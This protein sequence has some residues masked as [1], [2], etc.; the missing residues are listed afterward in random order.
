MSSPGD[1]QHASGPNQPRDVRAVG[2]AV[3]RLTVSWVWEQ[4]T[5][6][7]VDRFEVELGPPRGA[8]EWQRD[9]VPGS[10]RQYTAANLVPSTTYEVRVRS[11]RDVTGPDGS[12]TSY[13]SPWTDPVTGQTLREGAGAGCPVWPVDMTCCKDWPTDPGQWTDRHRDAVERATEIL[14]VLT[15]GKYGPCAVKVRPCSPDC[16]QQVPLGTPWWQ[17][18][19]LSTG[20]ATWI[21]PVLEGGRWFN[22]MCGCTGPCGCGPMCRYTLPW[23]S[24]GVCQVKI[25]GQVIPKDPA[26]GWSENG[27]R[28]YLHRPD[29][30]CFPDCN[31]LDL[32]DTEPGT[33]SI[34]YW[35]GRPP[36]ALGIAAVS[37]LACEIYRDDCGDSSCRTPKG[38]KLMS[39]DGYTFESEPPKN[40][41]DRLSRYPADVQDFVALYNPSGLTQAPLVVSPDVEW[42]EFEPADPGTVCPPW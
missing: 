21:T 40:L 22:R 6:L 35:R 41:A 25:D 31:R 30:G 36:T 26:N 14:R 8:V 12:V 39:A 17:W 24:A 5:G 2:T 7:P 3:D 19:T 20:E 13:A 38:V 32:P 28:V 33:W 29:G 10:A 18:D 37:K 23:E 42:P 16:P 4:G 27:T 1:E 11:V 15:G 9:D 34:T